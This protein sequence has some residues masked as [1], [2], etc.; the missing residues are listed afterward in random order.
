MPLEHLPG[1]S[2]H[3]LQMGEPAVA[4]GPVEDVVLVHGLAAN[5]GFWYLRIAPRLA[6]RYRVTMLDLRGHGLSSI[7]PRGYTPRDMAG[8]LRDLMTRLGIGS[9][10]ILGHSYGGQV[11]IELA[12]MCPDRVRGL[13]VADARQRSLQPDAGAPG[14]SH[15]RQ[16]RDRIEQSGLEMD[17]NTMEFGLHLF[18][19]MARL[20]LER[21]E[22]FEAVQSA[23]PTPFSGR[24]GRRMAMRW[25]RLLDTTSARADM[26]NADGT[27]VERLRRVRKPVLLVYGER[28]QALPSGQAL[29]RLWPHAQ[30]VVV[31][32]AGH[33][34]P[35]TM[36]ERLL[37][38]VE[39]F[40]ESQPIARLNEAMV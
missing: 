35:S 7:P 22:A 21:P 9:A 10:W 6:L 29:K 15:W 24:A 28:S 39:R 16:I 34:F 13:I 11:A 18:E 17:D 38:P 3:H 8:D 30:L 40:I 4:G 19:Q 26:A 2:I 23:V 37:E 14:A 25:L 1:V 32:G 33:F 12:S 31:P 27:P 20:R 5:L 36:P